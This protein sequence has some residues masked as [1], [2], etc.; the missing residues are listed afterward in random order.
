MFQASTSRQGKGKP[1]V[2]VTLRA[3]RSRLLTKKAGRD[4]EWYFEE[5]AACIGLSSSW[6]PLVAIAQSGGGRRSTYVDPMSDR[7][8][9]DV[10]RMRSIWRSLVALDAEHRSVI[11]AAYDQRPMPTALEDALGPWC[12]VA[13]LAE[14]APTVKGI[15]GESVLARL[16]RA[17]RSGDVLAL[18]TIAKQADRL[19]VAAWSAFGERAN[20]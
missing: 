5:S 14:S 6:E 8:I 17:A 4:L 9:E 7:R 18:T 16:D 19:I 12:G 13:A 2:L 1:V 10:W 3:L 15:P 20:R 11:E